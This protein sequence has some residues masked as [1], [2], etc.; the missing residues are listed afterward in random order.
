M[1][2]SSVS[3]F[4]VLLRKYFSGTCIDSPASMDAAR[5]TTASK[6]CPVKMRSRAARSAVSAITRLAPTGI[7]RLLP[8]ERLSQTMTSQPLARSC[9]VTTLP[10]YPAP[11]VTRTRS[12]M[13]VSSFAASEFRACP[14]T[15]RLHQESS[16]SASVDLSDVFDDGASHLEL[17]EPAQSP[18]AARAIPHRSLRGSCTCG[19]ARRSPLGRHLCCGE[20]CVGENAARAG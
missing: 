3:E 8:C 14:K 4:A 7:A 1:A 18:H 6:R 9:A 17:A 13:R 5:C 11:P 2:S 15:E 19:V 16:A 20:R 10:M 12:A